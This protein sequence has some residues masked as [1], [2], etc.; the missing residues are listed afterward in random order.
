MWMRVT[1]NITDSE[2][3]LKEQARL[4]KLM[5]YIVDRVV[6][7]RLSANNRQKAEK[8]RKAIEKIKQKEK[9]DENEE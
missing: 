9:Q 6:A 5:L 4:V 1:L 8:S 2:D 3:G 7:L